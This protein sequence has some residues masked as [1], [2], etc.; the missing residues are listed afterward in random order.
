[1]ELYLEQYRSSI[2]RYV[3]S[4][5]KDF[6]EA[7]EITQDTL[8]RA[9]DHFSNLLDSKKI[10]PWLY[11]IATNLYLDRWR[12]KTSKRNAVNQIEL[13]SDIDLESV[14]DE[15]APQLQK[16][17]ECQEMSECVQDYFSMLPDNYRAI[18]L[19]HDV[20]GLTCRE[21]SHV[22]DIS[23]YNAKNR[24]QRSREK[25][26]KILENVCNFYLDERGVLVCERK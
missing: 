10:V 1:M 6:N 14:R 23:I 2:L 17:M 13:R 25:L 7:E 4:L 3:T 12:S 11:R 9:Y 22:L 18:I 15:N 5:E 8:L 20:E 21:I 16:I 24:L 26:K 19:L